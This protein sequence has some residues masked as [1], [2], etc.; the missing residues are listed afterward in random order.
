[1]DFETPQSHTSH[2]GEEEKV[3][4][5][6]FQLLIFRFFLAILISEMTSIKLKM[7]MK[8]QLIKFGAKSNRIARKMG[9][10]LT[11]FCSLNTIRRIEGA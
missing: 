2:S 9:L 11:S 5:F 1:M 3:Q 10:N 8:F 4:P 7:N 6:S